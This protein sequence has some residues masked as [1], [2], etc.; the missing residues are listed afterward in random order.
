MT[1]IYAAAIVL[2]W[3]ALGIGCWLGWQLL[4]QNGRMLLRLE[5][6]EKRLD[7]L[8][9]TQPDN[10]VPESEKELSLVTSPDTNGENDRANRFS[11][12]SLARSKVKRD[13][14]K[15]GTPAPDFR[16]PC[17]DGTERSLQDF[18]GQ[19]VLLV[20]SDPHCGP[21][22]ALAPDLEKFH[23]TTNPAD[24]AVVMISRGEPN[25]NRAKVN[26]DGLTFPVLL[27]Q[28]WE[29]SRLYAIFAT[30]VAYLLDEQGVI[31]K[32]VAVGVEPI[33]ALL[34]ELSR[35][36]HHP[37]KA[38]AEFQALINLSRRASLGED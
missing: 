37:Q 7:E 31:V 24:P 26:E 11:N 14:L 13:G 33:Q 21:C 6:L 29:I 34:G 17:L 35:Q 10:A 15:A 16:L 20:L 4:R 38:Q 28:R 9:F 8:E 32:D 12:R 30:P 3:I 22:Q 25:E 2:N 19:R 27:Q 5:E 1:G 23:L 18:R 36:T